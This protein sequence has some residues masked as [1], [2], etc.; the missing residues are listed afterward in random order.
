MVFT[1][2]RTYKRQASDVFDSTKH[3]PYQHFPEI[4]DLV[5]H[6]PKGCPL[7]GIEIDDRSVPLAKYSHPDRAAYLLGSE[8]I[9]LT[10]KI[11]N[12]CHSLI[13]IESERDLCLNVS[14]A[15]SLAI[16]HRYQQR[17]RRDLP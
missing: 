11:R 5:D 16:W 2:G 4:D 13:Q 6:L 12:R 10:D 3:I 15:G 14:V 1:I 7:I 17:S 8:G 9:G